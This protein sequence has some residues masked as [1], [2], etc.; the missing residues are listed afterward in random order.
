MPELTK[1]ERA[2]LESQVLAREVADVAS[3]IITG[4]GKAY[5]RDK[6]QM[7]EGAHMLTVLQGMVI[8]VAEQA[9]LMCS[10]NPG[11]NSTWLRDTL[12][13]ELRK[14]FNFQLAEMTG[15]AAPINGTARKLDS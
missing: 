10:V 9:A 13:G 6:A 2:T 15:A 4:W 12:E 14:V 5:N 7:T 1:E 11:A 3:R 8:G